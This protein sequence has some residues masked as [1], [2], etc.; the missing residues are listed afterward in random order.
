MKK[1]VNKNKKIMVTYE[2]IDINTIELSLMS[3]SLDFPKFKNK[4]MLYRYE[5]SDSLEFLS[6]K[7][8][9]L[10]GEDE[11]IIV[12]VNSAEF[13]EIKEF[14]SSETVYEEVRWKDSYTL[15]NNMIHVYKNNIKFWDV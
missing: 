10:A 11:F 2:S 8:I 7:L 1:Q 12:P 5:I 9:E 3:I 6:D 13:E 4:R 14:L 15:L